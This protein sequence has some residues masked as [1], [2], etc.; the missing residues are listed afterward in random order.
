MHR[1]SPPH[2]PQSSSD[3]LL[4]QMPDGGSAV[5]QHVPCASTATP[6]PPHT[7]HA[8]SASPTP[9]HRPDLSTAVPSPAQHLPVTASMNPTQ[10]TLPTSTTPSTHGTVLY[11]GME[12][13]VPAQSGAHTHVPLPVGTVVLLPVVALHTRCE[14]LQSA[15]TRQVHAARPGASPSATLH[16]SVVG[17]LAEAELLLMQ[18][19]SG[20]T[21][22]LPLRHTTVRLRVSAVGWQVE[23]EPL[24]GVGLAAVLVAGAALHGPQGPTSHVDRARGQ[25]KVLQARD[26]GGG[27]CTGRRAQGIHTVAR[28]HVHMHHDVG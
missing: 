16:D 15:S 10:H 26:W 14:P 11:T 21:S 25:G 27:G 18:A 17:G 6:P 2:T 19:A 22:P 13:S 28:S 9:Q 23:L 12:Q 5:L 8:S 7:P 4:Q 20:I 24:V 3:P 1:L